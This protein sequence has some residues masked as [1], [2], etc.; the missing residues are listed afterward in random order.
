MNNSYI[1][2]ANSKKGQLLF[3]LFRPIDLTILV[4][5]IILS[6]LLLIIL[7]GDTATELVIKLFPACTAAILVF[8]VAYYH[9]VLV[10][11]VEM[12]I[13]Y[14]NQSKYY[15]RGW[16]AWYGNETEKKN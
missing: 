1:I 4:I 16:C 3:N 10:F 6:F 14:T 5:G 15:W 12:Y 11:L 13:Y 2:P 8:P 7:P 9:N